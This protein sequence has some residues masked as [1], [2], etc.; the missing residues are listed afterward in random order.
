MFASVAR[1]HA[2]KPCMLLLLH[3]TNRIFF[4]KFD[5]R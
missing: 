5:I 2:A 3:T 1:F 4:V